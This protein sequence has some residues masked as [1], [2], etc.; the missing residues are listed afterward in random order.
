MANQKKML[1]Q[2]VFINSLVYIAASVYTPYISSYYQMNGMSKLEIGMIMSVGPFVTLF[3][4]PLWGILSDYTGKRKQ[5]LQFLC[6]AAAAT[7]LLYFLG[8]SV[9]LMFVCALLYA[10]F[11]TALIPLSDAVITQKARENHLN[12]A[13]IR[14]GGTIGYAV[15]T[16][17]AGFFIKENP[18]CMFLFTIIGYLL[19]TLAVSSVSK[20]VYMIQKEMPVKAEKRS[21]LKIF[22]TNEVVYIFIFAVVNMIGLTIVN[23]FLG[24]KVLEM[25]FDQSLIGI[26]NFLSAMS[27]VPVLL[28]INRWNERF[29]AVYL[30]ALAVVLTGVRLLLASSDSIV[31][32]VMSQLLQ[33]LTYMVVFYTSVTY[34][35]QHTLNGKASQAQTYLV[36]LQSGL[37]AILANITAGY[38]MGWLGT[39]AGFRWI[40]LTV[41]CISLLTLTVYQYFTKQRKEG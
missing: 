14:M 15:V 41:M 13:V 25:G 4:Q 19:L 8:Y 9:I 12:Y 23:S 10:S 36:M 29:R 28:L 37:G 7:M 35:S 3:I 32:V 33:G 6:I 39:S 26:M 34:I 16:I 38:I 20:D 30:M 22:D 1:I 11:T 2:F 24:P 40:G 31:L 18:L 5:I 27:E 17:V 21:A